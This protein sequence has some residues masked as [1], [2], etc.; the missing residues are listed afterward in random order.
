MRTGTTQEVISD[1]HRVRTNH[2]VKIAGMK[3]IAMT[4]RA[5]QTPKTFKFDPKNEMSDA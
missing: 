5:V 2:E 4:L 1:I 3:G